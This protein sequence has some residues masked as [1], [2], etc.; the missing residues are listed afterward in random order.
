MNGPRRA[1]PAGGHAVD[2]GRLLTPRFAL[3][4]A[5][6][7]V[8]ALLALGIPT[9]IIA[10]PF[11]ARMTPT[12]PVQRGRVAGVGTPDGSSAGDVSGAPWPPGGPPRPPRGGAPTTLGG[13]A[14]FLAIGCP[15]CNK[16]VVASLG[17]SGALSIF[18]PLQPLIGAVSLVLLAATLWW[19]VRQLRR[20][21]IRCVEG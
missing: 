18:A 1:A 4:S 3:A 16:L 12:E 14:A 5:V 20:P 15:I 13:I 10:N 2:E 7:T 11:F 21:C 8:T 9:A 19:R 17:V 6:G